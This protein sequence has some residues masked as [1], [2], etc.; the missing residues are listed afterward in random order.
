MAECLEELMEKQSTAEPPDAPEAVQR[1]L[2]HWRNVRDQINA[3]VCS[4]RLQLEEKCSYLERIVS[5]IC[6]ISILELSCASE[7]DEIWNN[8]FGPHLQFLV[9]CTQI[10]QPIW[11]SHF[12]HIGSG[13]VGLFVHTQVIFPDF[14][15]HNC[16][17]GCVWAFRNL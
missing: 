8:L 16:S 4:V 11:I 2:V 6:A 3:R 9:G 12:R 15:C 14:I 1:V 5:A 17:T 10:V 7:G 13:I